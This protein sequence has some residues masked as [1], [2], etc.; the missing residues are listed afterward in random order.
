MSDGPLPYAPDWLAEHRHAVEQALLPGNGC[1]ERCARTVAEAAGALDDSVQHRPGV[2]RGRRDHTQDLSGSGLM[3]Q[4]L[5]QISRPLL[6]L[7]EEPGVLN[8]E[9]RF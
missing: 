7:L 2:R 9:C 5:A 4:A 3:L 8:G 1:V 6:Q